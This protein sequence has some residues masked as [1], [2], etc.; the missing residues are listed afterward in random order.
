MQTDHCILC[1][2]PKPE[3]IQILP[4]SSSLDKYTLVYL[5][6]GI[7][8]RNENGLQ[9]DK[10]IDGSHKQNVERKKPDQDNIPCASIYVML[11]GK[12]L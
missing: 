9:S 8:Y 1:K 6:N 10:N 7:L 2:N 12:K 5:R 11:F 3:T 4:D